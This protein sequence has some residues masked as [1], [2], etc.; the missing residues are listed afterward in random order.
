MECV[1]HVRIA[2][3]NYEMRASDMQRG[4]AVCRDTPPPPLHP[5]DLWFISTLRAST[6]FRSEK[7]KKRYFKMNSLRLGSR[8]LL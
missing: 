7:L 4:N 8:K 2:A 3:L 6:Q 1:S 5:T